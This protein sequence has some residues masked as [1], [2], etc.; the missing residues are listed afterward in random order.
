MNDEPI[1]CP[2]CNSTQIHVDKR[3]FKTGR[4]IASGLLTGN[5]LVAAA[6]GGIGHD[7]IELTCLKCG[8]K[9]GIK[10]IKNNVTTETYKPVNINYNSGEFNTVIC[11]KCGG[12]TLSSHKYCSNCGKLLDNN[13]KRI[14]LETPLTVSSCPKCKQLSTKGVYCSKCGSK[15]PLSSNKGCAGVV[16]IMIIAAFLFVMLP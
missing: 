11:S 10:D 5:I 15:I 14:L 7:K 1:K 9:F 16:L 8:C 3:G 6:A 2:K 13:D 4:A 12:K